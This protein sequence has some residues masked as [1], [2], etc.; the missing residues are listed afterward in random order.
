MLLDLKGLCT[1]D[2]ISSSTFP[3]LYTC[4]HVRNALN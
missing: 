4:M 3:E 1:E 2:L